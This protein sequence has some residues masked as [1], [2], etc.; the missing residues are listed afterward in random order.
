MSVL[1]EIL[2]AVTKERRNG[3]EQS[4]KNFRFDMSQEKEPY[5]RLGELEMRE[6]TSGKNC[7]SVDYLCQEA[8]VSLLL[9]G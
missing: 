5:E 3:P 6:V 7:L 2:G 4:P 8:L 9:Q 1:K